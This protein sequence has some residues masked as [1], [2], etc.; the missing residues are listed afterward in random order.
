VHRALLVR[1]A[2]LACA[3]AIAFTALACSSPGARVVRIA[4]SEPAPAPPR[5]PPPNREAV[6]AYARRYV[7]L[8]WEARP[9]HAF[10][11]VLEKE[12]MRVDTPDHPSVLGGWSVGD[13]VGVPYSW[14]G[15]DTPEDFARKIDEGRPAGYVERNRQAR[16]S[17]YVA[18]IDCSGLVSRSWGLPR[19]FST[20]ELPSVTTRLG[21][22]SE[23]QPGDI[24]NKENGHVLLF[25]EFGDAGHT[26]LRVVEA[27]AWD[28]RDWKTVESE[29]AAD[30]LVHDGFV[31][32]RDS[33]RR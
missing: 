6:V 31:P 3:T 21:A 25:V 20:R 11:G 15:F 19:N 22:M 29:Y 17:A 10:H 8:R 26:L 30:R 27:G 1:L 13:N 12:G 18:G 23:L 28:G 32:L 16:G 33:R 5:E 14:G 4:R 24:L 2:R 9:E 7:E